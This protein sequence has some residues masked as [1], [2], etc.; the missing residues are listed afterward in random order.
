MSGTRNLGRITAPPEALPI[1]I[2][3]FEKR[4]KNLFGRSEF[5]EIPAKS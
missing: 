1:P 3:R 5:V 4:H 2:A